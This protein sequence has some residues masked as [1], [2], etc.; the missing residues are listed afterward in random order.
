MIHGTIDLLLASP[1]SR[2]SGRP[3]DGPQPPHAPELF[4]RIDLRAGLGVVGDRYFNAPAHRRAS[5]TLFAVESLDE[6]RGMLGLTA[7]LDPALTRRN[8]ITRG[9]DV[10]ALVGRRFSLD[11]GQGPVVLQGNRPA[12]PCAWMDEVLAP[13]AFKALRRRGGVRC[14]PLSDGVLSLGP[15]TLELLEPVPAAATDV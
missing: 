8:V 2:Y 14:E 11:S 9:L 13:G 10:D 4:D 12:H 6:V 5:V 15:V 7:P 3:S 1:T